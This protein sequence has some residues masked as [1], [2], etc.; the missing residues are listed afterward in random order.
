[1]ILSAVLML[2]YLEE[3]VAA[4]KLEDAL[5]KVL[6]EGQVVTPDLGGNAT[7]M[8]M[9]TEVRAKLEL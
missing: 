2:N 9:A 7:T 6:K 4:Q 1:M 8:E 3:S 5:V